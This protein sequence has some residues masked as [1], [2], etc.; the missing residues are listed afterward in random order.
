MKHQQKTRKTHPCSP[1]WNGLKFAF[2]LIALL[3][4]DILYASPDRVPEETWFGNITSVLIAV[5]V[6]IVTCLFICNWIYSSIKGSDKD[7]K[8]ARVKGDNSEIMMGCLWTLA[9]IGSIV[10]LVMK[11][12]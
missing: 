12:S 1:R 5:L 7:D 3:S 9:V 8:K 2:L 11:C 6:I 4:C 10:T